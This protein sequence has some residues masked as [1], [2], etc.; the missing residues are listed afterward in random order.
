MIGYY[1]FRI[2]SFFVSILPWRCAYAFSDFA[3]FVMGKIIG[4]RKEVAM[5]NLKLSFPDKSEKELKQILKMT[6]K[7]ITDIIIE[8]IKIERIKLDDLKSRVEIENIEIL[9]KLYEENKSVVAL[10]AHKGNWEWLGPGLQSRLEHEGYVAYKPLSN[11]Y[12]D[13]YMQS[14]RDKFYKDRMVNFKNFLR[15]IINNKDKKQIY[16]FATDQTPTKSEIGAWIN[17]MNQETAFFNG[18]EKIAKSLGTAVVYI[19]NK[20]VARGKYRVKFHLI[21][22]DASK[23]KEMDIMGIYA[24]MLENSLHEQTYDWLW[25]HR[26]W[27]HKRED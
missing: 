5:T 10:M 19:E 22:E 6:Y 24:K 25:T 9:D 27:K 13:K 23:D 16:F 4:Y 15:F 26:R 20:R 17:F 21:T 14:L 3:A 7:N 8:N 2:F 12:F 1:F 18:G 11:K